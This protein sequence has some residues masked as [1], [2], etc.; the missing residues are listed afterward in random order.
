V[1]CHKRLP[2]AYIFGPGGKVLR[3]MPRDG[4]GAA[5]ELQVPSTIYICDALIPDSVRAFT[6]QIT[7]PGRDNWFTYVTHETAA[8]VFFPMWRWREMEDLAHLT[9]PHKE[10]SSMLEE[11]KQTFNKVGGAPRFLLSKIGE[12]EVIP[13]ILGS[14]E[15]FPLESLAVLSTS[16]EHVAGLLKSH[17]AIHMLTTGKT[18]AVRTC[19]GSAIFVLV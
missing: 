15:Q 14:V 17:H 12:P 18:L 10:L 13:T 1:Y 11:A 5:P 8:Q 2:L 19:A 9:I 4:A 7:S 6:I 3:A 16:A